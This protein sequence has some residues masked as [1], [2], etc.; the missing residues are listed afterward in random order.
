MTPRPTYTST[1]YLC[2]GGDRQM[3]PDKFLKSAIYDPSGAGRVKAMCKQGHR[4]CRAG[5]GR[6]GQGGAG[7]GGGERAL[8]KEDVSSHAAAGGPGWWWES[9]MDSGCLPNT[10]RRSGP[11]HA[12][13]A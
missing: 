4:Q 5:Q 7:V 1:V 10:R 9:L 12:T 6:T 8:S 11:G 2:I 13:G 3:S